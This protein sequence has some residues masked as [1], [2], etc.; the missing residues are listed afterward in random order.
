MHALAAPGDPEARGEPVTFLGV[1]TSPAG[2]ALDDQLGLPAGTGLMVV[3]VV[4]DSPAAAVLKPH[5]VLTRLD[6][7]ILIDT[8]QLA[9]LVRTHRAGEEI[10]L[11][12]IRGGKNAT[13]RVKLIERAMPQAFHRRVPGPG[14]GQTDNRLFRLQTDGG[15]GNPVLFSLDEAPALHTVRVF[16]KDRAGGIGGMAV[17]PADSRFALT[18]EKG[19]LEV[20]IRAGARTLVAKDPQ[21]KTLFDGP[22]D[23]PEQRQAMPP[24]VRERFEQMETM[25]AV[26]FD[27]APAIQ[28]PSLAAPLPDDDARPAAGP[29]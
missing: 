18:D 28:P 26:S 1:E 29:L 22:V 13:V 20:A 21:G 10:G 24:S 15:A 19:S 27:A 17:K 6:D 23:T 7:Q 16:R 11:G 3:S 25:D 2:P 4:P 12:Y 9:V 5:D 8:R 14:L